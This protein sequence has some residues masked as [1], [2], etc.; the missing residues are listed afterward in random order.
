VGAIRVGF[1]PLITMVGKNSLV[2]PGMV[3]EPGSVIG[4]D[5]IAPDYPSEIVRSKDYIQTK[6]P[7]YE[8]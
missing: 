8:T 1:D 4:P 7:P 5:V 2:P 3:V 6:R